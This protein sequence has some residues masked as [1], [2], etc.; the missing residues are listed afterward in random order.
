MELSQKIMQ[1]FEDFCKENNITGKQKEEKFEQYLEIL[2][3]S[4][5]EPLEA[6]GIIAAQSISEP[7]T[8]M[9]CDYNERVILKKNGVIKI[10]KIGEFVDGIVNL[11]GFQAEGWDVYD[12]STDDIYVPSITDKE[13]I[14]WKRILACS[15]HS[16]PENLIKITTRSGREITATDSHSFVIRKNN[17][18]VPIAGS[19]LHIGCRIPVMKY[20]PENCISVV[21]TK[22]FF[23]GDE[24]MLHNAKKPLPEILELDEDLGWIFGA[25]LAEGNATKNYISISNVDDLFLT[26]VRKFSKGFGFTFNEY[27]N[28]RGFAKGHDIRINSTLLSYIMKKSCGTGSVNK[29]IPSFAYSAKEGFVTGLLKGYFDGDGNVSATRGVIRA[30]SISKELIDGVCLLLARFGIFATKH[31]GK[32]Y[33]LVISQKYSDIFRAKIGFTIRKKAIALEDLSSSNRQDFI[34]MFSG[35]DNLFYNT[36]KK[37]GYPIRYVNNFTKRQKIGRS[38]ILK[39]I[40]LFERISESRGIDVKKNISVMKKMAYSDVVWDEIVLIEKVA[41]S[42][43]YVYDFTVDGTETFTTFDGI[44]THNTMRTYTLATQKDRLSKVTQG[45]PRLIEIF[46]AKKSL[47][48]QMKIYLTPEYNTKEKAR[49]IADDIKSKKVRDVIESDS[50]DLVDLKIELDVYEGKKENIIELVKKVNVEVSSRGNKVFIK[51]KKSDVRTLR[52][53][54]AKLLDAHVDGIKGIEEV[55]VVKEGDEWMIQT[56]GTNLKKILKIP[57]VDIAR[58]RSNDIFQIYEVL[59]IE[60]A[61]AVIFNEARVT[62]DEQGLDVDLRHLC[63]LADIMTVNGDVKAIGRY[64]VSGAKTSVLARANFEETKKHLVNASFNGEKDNLSGVIENVLV[65]QIIPVGTGG[66][67]LKVDIDKMTSKGKD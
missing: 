41:P 55:I 21:E 3:K 66:V 18:I 34:D 53:L 25:Y 24:H 40:N 8:Q 30:S 54:R 58:T 16:S 23:V 11:L 45:L 39:Y 26:R 48:K 67:Q 62:L 36:A 50:I 57:G 2:E 12:M 56:A 20:L 33:A 59:G 51:P 46:D 65:V 6:V 52:K 17:S 38:A 49:D 35:F 31:H 22:H 61:R 10:A 27:D 7:A 13:K 19:D 4:Y 29:R 43:R 60:A 28:Y 5:Y 63:L 9:S 1:I 64:G 44:I 37:I 32:E 15:R 47:E 14:E 42:S